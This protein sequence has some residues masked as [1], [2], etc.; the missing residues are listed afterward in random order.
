MITKLL[1]QD[2]ELLSGNDKDLNFV[3]RN[4]DGLVVDITGATIVWALAN[5]PLSKSRI[6]TYTSPTNVTIT[7]ALAGKYTVSIQD[8]DTEPL[9]PGEYY[10]E[11]RLTSAA[12]KKHTAAYGMV[13]VR[14]NVID[15]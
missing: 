15:T 13:F 6:I 8:T 3:H 4:Q 1:P 14:R 12:G 10:H 7:D 5:S 2:F 9:P 11:V